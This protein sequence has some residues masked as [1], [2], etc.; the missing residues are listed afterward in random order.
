PTVC[1]SIGTS[2]IFATAPIAG[3]SYSLTMLHEGTEPGIMT[4]ASTATKRVAPYDERQLP[5]G[6]YG[7]RG[8]RHRR[9][10][11]YA[12]AAVRNHRGGDRRRRRSRV[13]AAVAAHGAAAAGHGDPARGCARL[14]LAR[15]GDP[16]PRLARPDPRRLAHRDLH[17][18]D[19]PP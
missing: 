18:A 15:A 2:Q 19:V 10:H 4:S 5:R 6:G 11:L 13:G 7:N 8:R 3:F 14:R 12:A 17:R 1:T 9:D 16:L